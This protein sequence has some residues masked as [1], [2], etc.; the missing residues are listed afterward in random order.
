MADLLYLGNS[1]A[2]CVEIWCVF[3]DR[4]TLSVA[5]T[6]IRLLVAGRDR[7]CP[8]VD[9]SRSNCQLFSKS[10]Q[11]SLAL[12]LVYHSKKKNRDIKHGREQGENIDF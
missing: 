11:F 1:R 10:K 9:T 12:K 6:W 8:S 2:D 3:M 5:G 4:V 7:F